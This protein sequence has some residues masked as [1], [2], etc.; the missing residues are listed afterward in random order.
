MDTQRLHEAADRRR[1][2]EGEG[3]E[4]NSEEDDADARGLDTQEPGE[5]VV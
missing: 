1:V 2:A 5:E 3:G 4:D